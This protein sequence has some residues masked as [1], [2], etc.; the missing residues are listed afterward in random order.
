MKASVIIPT[1]NRANLLARCLGSLTRQTL[2]P[3]A[4]EVLVVDN[5]STDST[6][7]VVEDFADALQVTYV[8]TA[9]PGLHIG[10]HE[11]MRRARAD[12]LMF[13]DDDIE[14]EPTWVQVVVETFQDPE[15]A[16]VGGNNYPHFAVDPPGWLLQLWQQQSYKGRALGSLSILDFGQGVFE[17]DP[18]Y[19]WGCNFSIQREILLQA[20]GFH[21]DGLPAERL[22]FRG[23]GETH[24]SNVV[25]AAGL[26]TV[27]NSGASVR[28]LVSAERMTPAYLAQRA[29]A[30]GISDSYT[31]IRRNGGLKIPMTQN[32]VRRLCWIRGVLRT[33]IH[34]V[35]RIG[36]WTERE[37]RSIQ[38][39]AALA[40]RAGYE[41]HQREVRADPTLLDWILKQDYLQ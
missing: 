11:G 16:L 19:V 15:A 25:R 18:G 17:I 8:R 13:A 40:Y 26:K 14:A 6:A 27:F 20:R 36:D 22:R 39:S 24:V 3:S 38:R 35:L 7:Q 12:V 1:R 21:P 37:L 28:H 30:Q 10:R 34:S 4:F 41:F 32:A 23:D 31:I 29:Y 2:S 5:G 33:K 9:K